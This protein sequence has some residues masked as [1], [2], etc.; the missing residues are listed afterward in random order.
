MLKEQNEFL[1]GLEIRMLRLEIVNTIKHF[2]NEQSKIMALYDE[3]KAK[4]GNSYIDEIFNEWTRLTDK[5]PVK[6]RKKK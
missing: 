2:P 3:Y 5:K 1:K 6:R 4:G